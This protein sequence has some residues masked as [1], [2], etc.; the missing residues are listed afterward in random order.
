MTDFDKL[1]NFVNTRDGVGIVQDKIELQKACE[2]ASKCRSYLEV[3]TA[4]GNSLYCMAMRLMKPSH[5]VYV[6]IAEEKCKPPRE[7]ILK[8]LKDEN[9]SV[10][11]IH[12][13]SFDHKNVK[14]AFDMGPYDLVFI[15][16]AHDYTAV[17]SDAMSYGALAKKYILFHDIAI[18]DVKKAF[19][20]YVWSHGYKNV[21][22]I[23][24][25]DSPYGYG[26]I[27]L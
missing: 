17:I 14:R 9:I 4:E 16:A 3:G 12:G 13:S 27:E 19:D 25:N 1:W 23:H 6:D 2:I 11:G 24:H 22:I 21:Q 10:T 18:P 26:V 7:A 20:W 8:L 15:D 5:V